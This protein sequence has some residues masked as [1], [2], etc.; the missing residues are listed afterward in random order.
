MGPHDVGSD[1]A[2]DGG[3]EPEVGAA[4]QPPRYLFPI[5]GD[6]PR[7]V[8]EVVCDLV[9]DDPGEL[10][11]VEPVADEENQRGTA[12]GEYESRR[13]LAEFVLY[14]TE[15]GNGTLSIN[16][17]V[18]VGEDRD[19]ILEDV[20]ETFDIS[21]FIAEERP[22]TGHGSLIDLGSIVDRT[23]RW[24]CDSILVSRI[25]ELGDIDSVLVP[26]SDGP[27]SGMAIEVGLAL[28]RQNDAILELLHVVEPDESES[29]GERLLERG[30][31][32]ARTGDSIDTSL[33]VG[34]S[35][36]EAIVEHATVYDVTVIGAPRRGLLEQFIGGTVPEA[37]RNATPG[38]VLT[39]H[40]AGDDRSWTEKVL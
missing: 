29:D 14:A 22:E 34:S 40:R 21:T 39:V 38:T 7:E 33:V 27:H 24:R 16:E 18:R 12:A 6:H 36:S 30:V 17:V 9:T 25:E 35:V 20:V 1:L 8:F 10:F 3:A 4:E 32:H 2:V 23:T 28:A 11:V 19:E 31:A 15:Q 13:R 5:D 37:V 26:I